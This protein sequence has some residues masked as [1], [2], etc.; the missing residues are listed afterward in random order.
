VKKIIASA[1]VLLS[2]FASSVQADIAHAGTGPPNIVLIVTDDQRWD[3]LR[4]MPV[5]QA[6]L[7]N[8]GTTFENAFVVNPVSTASRVTILTGTYSHTNRVYAD[9]GPYGGWQSFRRDGSTIATWLN[10][11]GYE[12]S[13]IGKYLNQHTAPYIPKWLGQLGDIRKG[14]R[15]GSV[16]R[17]QA[18]RERHD[19]AAPQ[20]ASER[21]LDRRPRAA[22]GRLHPSHAPDTPLFLYFAPSAP[23][24]PARTEA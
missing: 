5:V 12:T 20:R 4:Y 14:R 8:K 1:I 24:E 16:L 7:V 17:L 13:L 15:R 10:R 2:F 18:H 6:K 22:L 19:R 21:L 3:T 9:I 11:D 23:S